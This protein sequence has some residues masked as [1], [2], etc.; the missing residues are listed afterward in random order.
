M[1]E[2]NAQPKNFEQ[3]VTKETK[4]GFGLPNLSKIFVILVSFC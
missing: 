2:V 4:A 3:K 1:T